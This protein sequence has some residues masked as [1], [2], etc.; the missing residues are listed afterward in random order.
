M[1]PLDCFFW[2][3]AMMHEPRV[4]QASI[5][6]LMEVIEDVAQTI[7]EEMVRKSVANIR[8]QCRAYI[9]AGGDHFESFLK[10]I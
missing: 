6:E 1:N 4:K 7:P 10:K 3:Y 8:K 5:E 9:V 2:S